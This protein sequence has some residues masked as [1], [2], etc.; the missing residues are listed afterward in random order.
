MVPHDTTHRDTMFGY[1]RII[2]NHQ[3][4]EKLLPMEQIRSI[5]QLNSSIRDATVEHYRHVAL[6]WVQDRLGK[7]LLKATRETK[8][9]NNRFLLPY[10]P[11]IEVKKVKFGKEV[12]E[13]GRYALEKEGDSMLIT[14]PFSWKEK[15]LIVEYVAGYESEDHVPGPLKNAVLS[16]IEYLHNHNGHIGHV[17]ESIEPWLSAY[18][19]YRLI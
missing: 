12:L 18:K 8:R 6:W 16:V 2:E 7:T 13:E 10:G 3:D 19:T 14:V 1:S 15:A 9:F 17:E 5:L 4:A 11:V